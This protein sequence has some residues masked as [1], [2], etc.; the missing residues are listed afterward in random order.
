MIP[1]TLLLTLFN[2]QTPAIL[3]Y[4]RCSKKTHHYHVIQLSSTGFA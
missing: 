1:D 4:L 2:V 3:K